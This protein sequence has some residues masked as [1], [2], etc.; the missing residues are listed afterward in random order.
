VDDLERIA[1]TILKDHNRASGGLRYLGRGEQSVCYGAGELVVLINPGNSANESN[2]YALQQWLT[3]SAALAGVKTPRIIEVGH[4]PR[5][6]ALMQRAWGRKASAS[7][8][9]S[10]EIVQWYYSMGEE[11]RK[12]NGIKTQG[13]GAFIPCERSCYCGKFAT[14]GGYLD[15]SMERYLFM[16]A[17]NQ[18][19]HRIKTLFLAQGII[20]QRELDKI[21]GQFHAAKG[22][23]VESVLVHYDNRLDNLMVDGTQISLLD[24]GLAFAGIGVAQELIK[25]FETA[26]LSMENPRVAAFLYGYGLAEGACM[27]AIERGKLMLILDGLAMSYGWAGDAARVAGIRAWLHTIKQIC[28]EW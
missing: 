22:W 7:S 27:N 26:P 3:T 23:P 4:R 10:E 13:F 21:A 5:P 11:V 8:A 24:W 20:S 16:G 2:N 18:D 14:W 1:A 19:A 15:A 12:I 25:L 28:D 6:Y 9:A 17:M